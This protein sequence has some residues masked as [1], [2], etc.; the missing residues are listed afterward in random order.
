MISCHITILGDGLGAQRRRYF[1]TTH[2]TFFDKKSVVQQPRRGCMVSAYSLKKVAGRRIGKRSVHLQ[3][4]EKQR[5]LVARLMGLIW[6][7]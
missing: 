5:K 2:P 3:I 6:D 4:S 7:S 1:Y